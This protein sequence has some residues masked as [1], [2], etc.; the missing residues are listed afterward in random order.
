MELNQNL[1][2][3]LPDVCNSISEELANLKKVSDINNYVL[4]EQDDIV[5]SSANDNHIKELGELWANLASIQQIF[6]PERYSF[7]AEKKDWHYFV[8]NKV[9][10]RSNLLLVAQKKNEYEVRGFLYLQSVTLPSSE[11]VLKGVIEDIYTKPQYRRQGIAAM[12]LK[13]SLEWA[14]SQNIKQAD[15]VSLSGSKGMPELCLKVS[16]EIKNEINFELLT[17]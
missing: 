11:L 4:F 3:H 2:N 15:I 7:N 13:I 17:V 14:R 9:E 8:Q 1:A 12:L 6:A 16:K 5:I 10:K